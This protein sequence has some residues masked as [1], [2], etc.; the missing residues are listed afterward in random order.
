MKQILLANPGAQ[1]EAYKQDIKEAVNRVLESG[2]YVLGKEVEAFEQEFADFHGVKYCVSVANGTDAIA[3]SLRA[4][5]VQ[6]GDEVITVSHT[7][8]A[9][10][11]AIE[12]IGAVPVLADIEL[13]SRCLD[14]ECLKSLLSDKTKA[15]VPV[16]I[17]GHPADLV[18]IIQFADEHGLK[19]LED[20]AQA[21][22]AE[23]DGRKVGTIALAGSFSFY[24]TK[25]LGAIG[26]GGGILTD[27]AEVAENLKM[28]KQYGWKDRY[29]S[30]IPGVNSR[31]DEMQ[32][33]ILRV[34]LK[35]LQKDAN[36]RNEIAR[37]YT[38]ALVDHPSVIAPSIAGNVKHAFHLYVVESDRRDELANYLKSKG[39]GCALHYPQAV[40]EQPAYKARIKGANALRNTE[41]LYSRILSIPMYPELS[42]EEV[43]RVCKALADF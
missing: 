28:L 9:T 31:L 14:P 22:C 43:G 29:I 7:A 19:V 34:K 39:I 26:D 42:D 13:G 37:K 38:E 8:V 33:A 35:G 6:K 11:A 4:F 16:H 30:D 21:H 12:Q 25:N 2:W 36:R 20:C 15:I 5:G 18:S 3:L 27:D 17:Y 10:V 41:D 23:I 24:P 32:A 40:H 1:Y